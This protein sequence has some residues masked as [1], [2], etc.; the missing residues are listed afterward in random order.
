[1]ISSPWEF[2]AALLAGLVCA[3]F[4][5]RA[6]R[7]QHRADHA[8][9]AAEPTGLPAPETPGPAADAEAIS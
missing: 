3:A 2:G 5:L 1:M 8:R 7:E 6:L 4:V 9:R